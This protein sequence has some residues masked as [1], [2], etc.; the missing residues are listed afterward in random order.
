MHDPRAEVLD[1]DV[2][3]PDESFHDRDALGGLQVERDIEL[4]AVQLVEPRAPVVR[5]VH[6]DTCGQRPDGPAGGAQVVRVGRLDLDHLGTEVAEHL[7]RDRR[8]DQRPEIEH[9]HTRQR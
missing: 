3:E 8:G 6:L 4:A 2:A 5:A 7:R 9:A 1:H